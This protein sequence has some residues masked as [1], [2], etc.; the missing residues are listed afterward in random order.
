D[1]TVS[2]NY[3]EK[4]GNY[5]PEGEQT[6]G[7]ITALIF[8]PTSWDPYYDP[9]LGRYPYN[10]LIGTNPFDV[11]ENWRAEQNV[12]RFIGSF[13]TT[14]TPVENLRINYIF[15]FDRTN[16]EFTYYQPPQSTGASF[17]GSIQ[18]P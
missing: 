9:E 17:S 16:E 4:E 5:L 14:V 6:Q 12:S 15:G 3:I 18:N 1:V 7:V 13:N 8:T 10:P 11:I 2:G